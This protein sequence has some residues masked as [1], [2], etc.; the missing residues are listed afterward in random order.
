MNV[1][2]FIPGPLE[3]PGNVNQEQYP[4]RVAFIRRVVLLHLAGGGIIAGIASVLPVQGKLTEA[5]ALLGALLLMLSIQRI[6]Q[7]GR[8]AEAKLAASILPIVLLLGAIT[9][10]EATAKGV[11][12]WSAGLGLVAMA[13]YAVSCGRDFS[14]P[15][16]GSLAW[17]GS[18]VA[19]AAIANARDLTGRETGLALLFNTAAIIFW[20]FDL[21]MLMARR[22]RGEELAA[23]VDLYRD[24]FNVFGYIPRVIIHWRKHRIWAIPEGKHRK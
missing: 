19:V 24:V 2:N 6:V 12:V 22:R 20:T 10:A 17:I 9:V 18:S 7:R 21:S 23:V 5:V 3:V 11:P 14:F 16:C 15:G 8:P 1:P 13:L 4:T